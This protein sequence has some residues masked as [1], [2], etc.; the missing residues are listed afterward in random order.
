[1]AAFSLFPL[2]YLVQIF[3]ST[4]VIPRTFCVGPIFDYSRSLHL[5]V[6]EIRGFLSFLKIEQHQLEQEKRIQIERQKSKERLM[7]LQEQMEE[8]RRIDKERLVEDA[9]FQSGHCC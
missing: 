5:F 4:I 9:I 1:M 3:R 6:E 2:S 8:Q 7:E